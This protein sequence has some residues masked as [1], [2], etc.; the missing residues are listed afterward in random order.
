MS[1]IIEDKNRLNALADSIIN[2]NGST[3]AQPATVEELKE[4]ISN[5]IPLKSKFA[6]GVFT[7][8]EDITSANAPRIN[9]ALGNDENGKPIKPNIIIAYQ[10]FAITDP[11]PVNATVYR[12]YTYGM[13]L[14]NPVTYPTVTLWNASL[15]RRLSP[16]S[17][18]TYY[19]GWAQN[20]SSVAD[21]DETGSAYVF[22]NSGFLLKSV[23][24]TYPLLAGHPIVWLQI[25][26]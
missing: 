25:K 10:P 15:L 23:L 1:L 18:G 17:G 13:A 14:V 19:T 16:A 22:N 20:G 21:S 7:P 9:F 6:S 24:D 2:A 8:S 4:Q 3:A 5:L 26:L 12:I 11:T